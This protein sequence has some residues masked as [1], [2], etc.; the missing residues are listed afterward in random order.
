MTFKISA[1]SSALQREAN[2]NMPSAAEKM[3]MP[4]SCGHQFFGC[5]TLIQLKLAKA[6]IHVVLTFKLVRNLPAVTPM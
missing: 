6:D 2:Q 1:H 3:V 4:A 5:S